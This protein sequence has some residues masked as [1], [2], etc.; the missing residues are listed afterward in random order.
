MGPDP[1]L[2]EIQSHAQL[3]AAKAN[4]HNAQAAAELL[5]ARGDV[6]E[7]AAAVTA[8]RA[9]AA[10]DLGKLSAIGRQQPPH[11]PPSTWRF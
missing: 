5:R 11:S 8:K 10:L 2:P 7:S 1:R 4:L 3:N 6:A 9:S